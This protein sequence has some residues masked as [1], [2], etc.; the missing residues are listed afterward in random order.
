MRIPNPLPPVKG[1]G[2]ISQGFRLVF[3][4][5]NDLRECI[6]SIRTKPSHNIE[7]RETSMGTTLAG[8][9]TVEESG[10]TESEARWA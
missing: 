10:T 2:P 8:T 5:V 6:I 7:V 4:A 1:T 3:Q 9:A